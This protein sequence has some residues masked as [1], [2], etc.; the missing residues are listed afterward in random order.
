MKN[1][2]NATCLMMKDIN[3]KEY[4][5]L[6]EYYFDI[7]IP[8]LKNTKI[9]I[10]AGPEIKHNQSKKIIKNIDEENFEDLNFLVNLANN[11]PQNISFYLRNINTQPYPFEFYVNNKNSD[12]CTIKDANSD[13]ETMVF[14]NP[15]LTKKLINIFNLELNKTTKINF[16]SPKNKREI[17]K[18]MNISTL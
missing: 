8:N 11:N 13:A 16:S 18:R 7:I 3:P 15:I 12:V 4:D 1:T 5:K 10:I 9:A 14:N 17:L 2:E 6:K